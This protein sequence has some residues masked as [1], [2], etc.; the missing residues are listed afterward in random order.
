MRRD[1]IAGI[2]GL[3]ATAYFV[4]S[5]RKRPI[6][7]PIE[8]S[9]FLFRPEMV[10]PHPSGIVTIKPAA[11]PPEDSSNTYKVPDVFETESHNID[12]LMQLPL[13]SGGFVYDA[14]ESG[15]IVPATVFVKFVR[16]QFTKIRNSTKV[17]VGGFRFLNGSTP[18]PYKKMRTWNP[19]TGSTSPYSGHAWSDSD[20]YTVVFCFS[21]PLEI[22]RYELRSSA[23]SWDHDPL[24]WK[25]DG[26]MNGSFWT[27]LDDR[28]KVT[29]VFPFDRGTIIGFAMNSVRRVDASA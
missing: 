18:I 15:V 16:F 19:H 24:N 22:T 26:S 9:P 29:T 5:S 21:E 17:E 27:V 3:A 23:V 12:E 10:P 4:Y 6:L 1:L 28:T 13:E 2:I 7:N 11:P 8:Y 25:V 14:T 20:Q